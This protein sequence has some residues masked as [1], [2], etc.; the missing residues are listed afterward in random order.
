MAAQGS[1]TSRPT[2]QILPI[3]RTWRAGA[4]EPLRRR[5]STARNI[6][7]PADASRNR[8][9]LPS[10]PVISNTL[11]R[12]SAVT[13]R[14]MARARHAIEQL[15][16]GSMICLRMM[17]SRRTLSKRHWLSPKMERRLPG[18]QRLLLRRVRNGRSREVNADQRSG[19]RIVSGRGSAG[20]RRIHRD[21]DGSAAA[22]RSMSGLEMPGIGG[23][24]RVRYRS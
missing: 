9:R 21:K 2:A 20:R 6:S 18:T 15:S 4:T 14:L 17:M 3:C 22:S 13:M 16:S 7:V 11:T 5:F 1:F 8:G 24:S 10:V 12:K 23:A 19:Q